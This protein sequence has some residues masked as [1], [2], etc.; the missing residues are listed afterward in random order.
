M[1]SDSYSFPLYSILYEAKA[2][3]LL[4]TGNDKNRAG[5]QGSSMPLGVLLSRQLNRASRFI[6]FPPAPG[7]ERIRE[8]TIYSRTVSKIVM[9]LSPAFPPTSCFSL[10]IGPVM[11]NVVN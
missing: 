7:S 5:L 6:R 8:A 10:L 11:I 3:Y 9:S 2:T 1:F 4:T